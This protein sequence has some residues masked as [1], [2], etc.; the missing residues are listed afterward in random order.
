[1]NFDLT[2]EQHILQETVREFTS[3]EIEPVAKDIDRENRL[4]DDLIKK[5]ADLKLLGMTLPEEYGGAEF[6][7]MDCVLAI[8]QMSYSGTGAWWLVAFNN[9]IPES[10]LEFGTQEQRRKYL[11]PVSRGDMYAS[12]QFTESETGSNP[13]AL[14]TKATLEGDH[15]LVNGV[16]RFSTF[17][18]RDGFAVLYAKNDSGQCTAFIVDKNVTGYT[19]GPAYD[20]MGGGGMEAV[21]V[22]YDQYRSPQENMLGVQGQGMEIL[23]RWISAEKIQQCGACVGIACAALAE[24][25]SYSK[26]R[27]AGKGRLSDLQ[28]TRWMLA[29]MQSKLNAA[30]LVTYRAALLKDKNAPDWIAEAAAAKMFVVPAAMEIV[31]LSRR[32]HGCYG[33]TKEFKIERLYRAIAGASAIAVSLEINKSIAGASL[34]QK[35]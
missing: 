22:Y 14:S 27:N 16:K 6:G 15:Y 10:V 30:R 1:M 13:K 8:E 24:A 3:R 33:Y 35:L 29:E 31:E 19:A 34:L 9:S 4:P 23:S 26:M 32:I 17:G 11:P 7:S 21:D 25:V 28:G 12:I 5:M 20:L 2:E 18:A